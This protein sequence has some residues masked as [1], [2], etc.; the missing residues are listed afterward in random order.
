MSELAEDPLELGYP[1]L[2]VIRSRGDYRLRH[3]LENLVSQQVHV[4]PESRHVLQRA[5]VKIEREATESLLT[6]LNE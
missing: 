2:Q 6:S 5:V 1:R 4:D 3:T